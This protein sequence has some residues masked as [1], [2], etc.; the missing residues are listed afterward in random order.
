MKLEFGLLLWPG[1]DSGLPTGPLTITQTLQPFFD[2]V[3]L[4][5]VGLSH[6]PHLVHLSM[7]ILCHFNSEGFIRGLLHGYKL[8][9]GC[10]KR[11]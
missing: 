3:I 1:D 9:A 11:C 5:H 10:G 4:E 8:W 7:S 2:N 6:V